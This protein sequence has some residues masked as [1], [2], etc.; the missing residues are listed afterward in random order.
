MGH[1]K[2]ITGGIR[3]LGGEARMVG[4]VLIAA[5]GGAAGHAVRYRFIEPEALGRACERLEVWWCALRAALSAFVAWGGFGW[6]ALALAALAL[7]AALRHRPWAAGHGA[8]ARRMAAPLAFAAMAVGGAGLMLYNGTGSAV[9][10][11]TAGLALARR[12]Q[13]RDV[14]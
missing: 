7:L 5:A 12:E 1:V 2:S 14:P 10:L 9:A 13:G 8:Y 4:G 6:A 3:A 11:V